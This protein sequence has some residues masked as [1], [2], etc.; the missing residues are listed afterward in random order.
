MNVGNYEVTLTKIDEGSNPNYRWWSSILEVSRD[1]NSIGTYAPER[2]FYFASEQ[3]TSEVRRYS[4]FKEDLYMVF[5]GM[6][7]DGKATVQVFLNPLVRWV[8]IGGIVMFFGTIL[9]M[10]PDKRE[11][12][13]V[14]KPVTTPAKL[15]EGRESE[16]V[17]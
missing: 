15:V 8:W 11:M 9:T 14:R 6:T 7:E 12:K 17:A 13:L 1:G 10:L 3:P 4:T 16:E 5:A 2:H